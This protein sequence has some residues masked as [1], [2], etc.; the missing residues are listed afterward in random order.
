[1]IEVRREQSQPEEIAL[2]DAV[3]GALL[4]AF[5][6]PEN[7]RHVRLL[8]HEPHRFAVPPD[9]TE[10]EL[11]T[12]ISIDAFEGRSIDAKR[13]L[14]REIVDS[15]EPLGVPR[16]HISIV[17]REIPRTNWGIRGGQAASDVDLGFDVNV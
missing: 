15:L 4:R 7:D 13:T 1:V 10:P 3:H 2:I 6:I 17:I 9:K 16:D 8:V 5:R 12:Q 11:F 14:Y